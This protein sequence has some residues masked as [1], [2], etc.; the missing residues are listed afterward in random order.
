LNLWWGFS[1]IDDW[2]LPIESTKNTQEGKTSF[3]SGTP[4]WCRSKT[5]RLR[6]SILVERK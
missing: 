3:K 4:V 1:A 6:R 2:T 5:L